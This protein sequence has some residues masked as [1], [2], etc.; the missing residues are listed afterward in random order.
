MSYVEKKKILD[1]KQVEA[2]DLTYVFVHTCAH[3]CG[4]VCMRT[5]GKSCGVRPGGVSRA[6]CT[7]MSQSQRRQTFICVWSCSCNLSIAVKSEGKK[8][9][10]HPSLAMF[11]PQPGKN[12]QPVFL[13]GCGSMYVCTCRVVH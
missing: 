11:L 9:Y 2:S 13:P 3:V 7:T 8:L 1:G 6:G 5:R 12:T 10:F 4:R